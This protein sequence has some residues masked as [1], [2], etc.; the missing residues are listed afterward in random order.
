MSVTLKNIDIIPYRDL[1][2]ER[3]RTQH[4]RTNC[5]H[6]GRL[7]LISTAY[8]G[9]WLEHLYDP[10]VWAKLFPEDK[11]IAV[12]QLKLFLEYHMCLSILLMPLL[13]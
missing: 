6:E 10:V 3:I 13:N 7:F 12:S 11:D 9:Y 2:L 1:M 8:P 4:I 5:A